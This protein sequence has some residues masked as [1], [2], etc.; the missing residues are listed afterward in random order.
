M[1]YWMSKLINKPIE[2]FTNPKLIDPT[3]SAEERKNVKSIH[4]TIQRILPLPLIITKKSIKFV[5]KLN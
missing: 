1:N 4:F 5:K 2:R 3:I